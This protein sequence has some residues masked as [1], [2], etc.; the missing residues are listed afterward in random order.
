MASSFICLEYHREHLLI[1][2]SGSGP[3]PLGC[4][5]NVI[6]LPYFFRWQSG[7]FAQDSACLTNTVSYF[8]SI[9]ALFQCNCSDVNFILFHSP[10]L[11]M[12]EKWSKKIISLWVFLN[13]LYGTRFEL[14]D[15]PILIRL[16]QP[17]CSNLKD[18]SGFCSIN[19][20]SH[21]AHDRWYAGGKARFL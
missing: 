20:S 19:L 15:E 8:L 18:L 21:L 9:P 7:I 10:W 13:H 16:G 6:G 2:Q 5:I 1:T 4:H 17:P 3:L 11:K 14:S 12:K